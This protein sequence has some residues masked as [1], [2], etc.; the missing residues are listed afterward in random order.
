MTNAVV[1]GNRIN[2]LTASSTKSM[3][4]VAGSTGMISNNRMQ[5]LSGSA[6][7]TG[8]ALSTPDAD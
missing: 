1:D 4:F 2:N 3:V 6:P 5:I 7:I 8:A